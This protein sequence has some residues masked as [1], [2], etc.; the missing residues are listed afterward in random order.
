MGILVFFH[1]VILPQLESCSPTRKQEMD[2]VKKRL[3]DGQKEGAIDELK[4]YTDQCSVLLKS[5]AFLQRQG[6]E[7]DETAGEIGRYRCS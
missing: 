6:H 4:M 1:C 7:K 3:C 5:V 2:R